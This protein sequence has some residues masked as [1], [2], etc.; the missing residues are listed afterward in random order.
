MFCVLACLAVVASLVAW[1]AKDA[2]TA[3]RETK[4]RMQL[5]QTE[6]LLDAGIL[7]FSLQSQ[8]NDQ[9][10]GEVWKPKLMLA[11]QDANASVTISI[12]KE[13]TNI[14]AKI[15]VNPNITTQSYVY[16]SRTVQ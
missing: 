15:G 2:M 5:L 14:T 6:R 4:L 10:D 11:G 8:Q 3:R 1:I 9:Y 13:Q 7:R 12:D 16:S